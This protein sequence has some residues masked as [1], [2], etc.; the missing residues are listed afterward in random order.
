MTMGLS[1]DDA[2]ASFLR[3]YLVDQIITD[4]PFSTID[5]DGV[6]RLMQIAVT[7]GRDESDDLEIGICGEHGAE[8]ASI[9]L[10]QKLG[11]DY[12]SCSVYR[13]PVARLA[14]AQA[15]LASSPGP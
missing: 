6:G 4:N 7:D 9:A 1:R 15:A 2:E 12:V 14:A 13:V 10:C 11:L 3:G 5:V 8:P